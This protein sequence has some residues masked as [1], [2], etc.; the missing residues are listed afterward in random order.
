MTQ[1]TVLN[2]GAG[3]RNSP[4]QLPPGLCTPDWREVRVDIDPANNP[5]ILGS[6]L[7]MP[8]VAN[9]SVDAVFCSHSIE[10]LYASELGTAFS[11]FRRV[12]RSD[13]LLVIVCPDLRKAAEWIVAGKLL[14]PVYVS[15]TG[16][17]VTPF[18]I[19]F[20][21]RTLTGHDKPYMA[22]RCGFTLGLLTGTLK[23][24]GFP[25]TAGG[26]ANFELSMVASRAALADGEIERL[27]VHIFGLG[28]ALP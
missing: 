18:D 3:S 22:H 8:A 5:D 24:M 26:R 9:E 21:H 10:H 14:D 6:M 20:G 1:R 16:T 13:G 12:L 27:A 28:P 11:E 23:S 19:V 2:V 25:A 15:P 4:A 17:P 7:D